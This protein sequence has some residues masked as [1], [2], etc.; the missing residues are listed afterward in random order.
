MI[1]YKLVPRSSA[2][3]RGR[4]L[5]AGVPFFVATPKE[6]DLAVE[7][8]KAAGVTLDVEEELL[9]DPVAPPAPEAA[10]APQDAPVAEDVPEPPGT[11]TDAAEAHAEAPAEPARRRR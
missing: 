6:R 1:R 4:A 7:Q 10:S 11:A 5:R 8:A 9:P 2:P 3:A